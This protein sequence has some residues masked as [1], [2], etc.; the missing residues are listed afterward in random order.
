MFDNKKGA[1]SLK[2]AKLSALQKIKKEMEEAMKSGI[3]KK[4]VTVE[5]DTDEGLKEG[6][7]K[8]EEVIESP[9]KLLGSEEEKDEDELESPETEEEE[10]SEDIDAE[11]ERL[12]ALK[13]KLQSK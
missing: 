12:L 2:S 10:D 3:G 1:D 13:A 11:I 6:L 7:E 8:A 4:S 5:A 9:E